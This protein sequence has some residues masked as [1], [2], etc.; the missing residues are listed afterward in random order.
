M[1]SKA[2]TSFL[3]CAQRIMQGHYIRESFCNIHAIDENY[4]TRHLDANGYLAQLLG[5]LSFSLCNDS[6]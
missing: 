3:Y 5:G 2:F 4:F 1:N 6:H